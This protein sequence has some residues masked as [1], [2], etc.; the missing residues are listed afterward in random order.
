MKVISSWELAVVGGGQ[1]AGCMRRGCVGEKSDYTSLNFK[2]YH[3]SFNHQLRLCTKIYFC[4]LLTFN[5]ARSLSLQVAKQLKHKLRRKQWNI[6]TA[7]WVKYFCC[8]VTTS[9]NCCRI[10]SVE[11]PADTSHNTEE[12]VSDNRYFLCRKI[13]WLLFDTWDNQ[14][15]PHPNLGPELGW[16]W[17]QLLTLWFTVMEIFSIL[18]AFSAVGPGSGVNDKKCHCFWQLTNQLC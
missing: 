4:C 1:V 10:V 14:W 15:C 6:F 3:K 8:L 12:M 9:A 16:T 13:N 11:T 18:F 7:D 2:T 5:V 17:H